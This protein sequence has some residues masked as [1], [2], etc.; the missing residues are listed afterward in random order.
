MPR[1]TKGNQEEETVS[2]PKRYMTPEKLY[3]AQE[4]CNLNGGGRM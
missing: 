1:K 4:A 2:N 3:M